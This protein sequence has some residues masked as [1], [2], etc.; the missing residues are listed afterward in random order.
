MTSISGAS[1]SNYQSP[2]QLLQAELQSEVNSG[3]VSSTDQSALSSA[4]NDI[5]SV[6]AGRRTDGSASGSSAAL[7]CGARRHQIED[8]QPDRRRSFER[9]ADCRSGHRT[10]GCVSGR[11]R[12]RLQRRWPAAPAALTCAALGA[13]GAAGPAVR[14][15][16]TDP[17][18]CITGIMAAHHGASSASASSTTSSSSSSDGSSSTTS[19]D[20]I[21]QQFLQSLQN[22]LSSSSIDVY[23]AIGSSTSGSDSSSSF[24]ALLINYQT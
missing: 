7:Q 16:P 5:N 11:I 23:S 12:Q 22:S 1:G 19:T 14:R 8:R 24:S 10:A 15:L 4:L 13:P 21:L 17:A 20:D 3:A 2:L 9:Q 6:A 18:A